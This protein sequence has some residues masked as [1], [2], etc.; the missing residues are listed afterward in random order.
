MRSTPYPREGISDVLAPGPIIRVLTV[1]DAYNGTMEPIEAQSGDKLR[2]RILA[3]MLISHAELLPR[4]DELCY[5]L[6]ADIHSTD[7][8]AE[9]VPSLLNWW[10]FAKVSLLWVG[11]HELCDRSTLFSKSIYLPFPIFQ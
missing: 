2:I 6:G 3:V 10:N 11:R 9:N 7:S 1:G 4:A 5:V 8:N